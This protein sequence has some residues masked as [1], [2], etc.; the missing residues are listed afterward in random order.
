M[1]EYSKIIT[2][3]KNSRGV[4][5]LDTVFGCNSGLK[6]DIKGCYSDCYSARIAKKYGYDFS[7]NVLRDFKNDKH[8]KSIIKK[9]N[10]IDLDFVRIGSNGDPSEDWEHTLKIIEQLKGINK[11][12][13]IITRHWKNL[14]NIHI[15]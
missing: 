2:L 10:K 9:I 6:E 8:L 14:N 13:V 1:R 3:T 11:K 5:S 12:I 4:T 7:K 15:R